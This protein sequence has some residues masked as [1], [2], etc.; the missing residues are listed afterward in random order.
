[1]GGNGRQWEATDSRF[2]LIENEILIEMRFVLTL[3][4]LGVEYEG[5][6]I[7]LFP[8]DVPKLSLFMKIMHLYVPIVTNFIQLFKNFNYNFLMAYLFSFIWRT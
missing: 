3:S 5:K 4:L 1:M 6:G 7:V 2:P 8:G